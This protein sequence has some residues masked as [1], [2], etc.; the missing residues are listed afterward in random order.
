MNAG[1]CNSDNFSLEVAAVDSCR[2][3]LLC[4]K[5][6]AP[7]TGGEKN[8]DTSV[9]FEPDSESSYIF[10]R[11]L[12]RKI[13]HINNCLFDC[14]FIFHTSKGDSGHSTRLELKC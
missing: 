13:G 10:S 2:S 14:L 5:H 4:G 3:G 11:N 9:G 1:H 12:S 7:K 8:E 6:S